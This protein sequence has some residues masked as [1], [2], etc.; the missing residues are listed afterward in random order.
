MKIRY[1]GR[2]YQAVDSEMSQDI[3]E[4]IEILASSVIRDSAKAKDKIDRLV[5][6]AKKV[7]DD[8]RR[9]I[10]LYE[11]K[12]DESILHKAQAELKKLESVYGDIFK[13]VL[14]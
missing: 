1:K 11:M 6:Q 8:V 7:E 2:L 13:K 14:P 3:K 12:K 9:L 10:K 4:D 5:K